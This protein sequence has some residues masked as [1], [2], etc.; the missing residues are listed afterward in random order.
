MLTIIGM[1]QGNAEELET[2]VD[3]SEVDYLISEYKMAFGAD[4]S[5]YSIDNERAEHYEQD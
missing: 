2:D 1:Y 3:P 5:I 4:W